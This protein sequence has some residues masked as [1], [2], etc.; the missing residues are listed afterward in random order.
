MHAFS[1][2][3]VD[4]RS[5]FQGKVSA[6]HSQILPD[7]SMREE[8]SNQRF[9][10]RHGFRE[11]QNSGRETIDAMHDQN[12]LTARFQ[13]RIEKRQRRGCVGSRR[14]HGQKSGRLI[15]RHNCV[16]FIQDGKLPRETMAT[17]RA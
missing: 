17:L 14:R 16:V 7:R 6:H 3:I 1:S 5:L 9:P 15:D 2:K 8:L 13:V 10:I 12:M 4:Q 11:Q